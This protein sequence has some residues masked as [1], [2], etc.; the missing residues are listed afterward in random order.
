[1][2]ERNP[3]ATMPTTKATFVVTA[4]SFAVLALAF[5][6]IFIIKLE[7]AEVPPLVIAFYRMAMATVLLLPLALACKRREMFAFSGREF[8]LLALGGGFLAL[9]F[10]AWISS[11]RYIP[12]ATSVVL[13]NSHPLFVVLAS[14]FFLGHKPA[15]L[16]VAGTLIGLIGMLIIS[17]D[18]LSHA[19]FAL[20]GDALAIVGA[21]AVVGYFIIGSK[22][23][24]RVS[25][26]GYVTPLYA[27]CALA[28]L[29]WTLA[30]GNS[31]YP[32]A[33]K[34]W[35]YFLALAIVPTILGHTVFNWAI[36]H[37]APA[38]ISLAFLGEPV[39]AAI[40]AYVIFGQRPPAATFIGGALVLGGIYLTMRSTP[41]P[42]SVGE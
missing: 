35:G 29:V 37:V 2:E 10:G 36:K 14:Y 6:S 27:V 3:P 5:S 38:T 40:L 22:V 16:S 4:M 41:V 34:V 42:E 21:L 9:H 33:G 32:F 19:E 17:K 18:G 20:K 25:L 30:S 11:L 8:F 7:H 31:L 39:V 26:L 15:R 24:T 12:I 1:M 23:R 13:V 28:L